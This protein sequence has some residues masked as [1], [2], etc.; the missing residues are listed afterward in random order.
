MIA[1]I[2]WGIISYILVMSYVIIVYV[3]DNAKGYLDYFNNVIML[4][5]GIDVGEFDVNSIIISNTF[6]SF[7]VIKGR[8]MDVLVLLITPFIASLLPATVVGF[9][10]NFVLV[11]I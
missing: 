9:I 4:V 3:I 2:V 1:Y 8:Q 11:E 5:L 7:D 10:T 6:I